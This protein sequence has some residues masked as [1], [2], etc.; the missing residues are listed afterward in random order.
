[1]PRHFWVWV[2]DSAMLQTVSNSGLP[3]SGKIVV[4]ADGGHPRGS[5]LLAAPRFTF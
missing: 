4:T 5:W 1:M 2:L 3:L